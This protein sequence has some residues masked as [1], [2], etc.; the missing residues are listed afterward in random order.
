MRLTKG[1][2]E[3]QSVH[4]SMS[5]GF[6]KFKCTGAIQRNHFIALRTLS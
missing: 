2:M 3:Y 6:M 5:D 4:P 1:I